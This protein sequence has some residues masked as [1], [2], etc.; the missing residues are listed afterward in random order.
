MARVKPK[1]SRAT[2]TRQQ[3][4]PAR[5][6]RGKQSTGTRHASGPSSKQDKVLALLRQPNGTSIDAIEKATGWQAHS[7][8]G[9]FSGV[10]KKKLKLTIVSEKVGDQRSYRIATAGAVA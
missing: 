3:S 10:V 2:T 8:R 5:Q 4:K 1:T 7:I 9:F 6:Q